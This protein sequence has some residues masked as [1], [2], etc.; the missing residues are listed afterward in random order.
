[1]NLVSSGGNVPSPST[2]SAE[3]CGRVKNS[4]AGRKIGRSKRE[5]I[6]TLSRAWSGGTSEK[7]P[8]NRFLYKFGW[9]RP[10]AS[11]HSAFHTPFSAAHRPIFSLRL[12]HSL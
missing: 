3:V 4:R 9:V 6:L 5:V 10:S 1:M 8:V 2:H 11:R 12:K 7:V